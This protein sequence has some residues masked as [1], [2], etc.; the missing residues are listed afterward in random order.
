[1]G[2]SVVLLLLCA[3]HERERAT[4]GA[5]AEQS[6][7]RWNNCSSRSSVVSSKLESSLGH[8]SLAVSFDFA[9]LT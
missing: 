7:Q 6:T 2:G 3:Q 8:N 9:R 4:I 1:M 5:G